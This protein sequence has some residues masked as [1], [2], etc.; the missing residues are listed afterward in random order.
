MDIQL[1]AAVEHVLDRADRTG[2]VINYKR[3]HRAGV[4]TEIIEEGPTTGSAWQFDNGLCCSRKIPRGIDLLQD[5]ASV[6]SA[7]KAFSEYRRPRPL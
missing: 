1:L 4:D 7:N 6:I 2:Y 3:A 5:D